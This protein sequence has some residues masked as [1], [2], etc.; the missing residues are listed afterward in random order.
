VLGDCRV[1]FGASQGPRLGEHLGGCPRIER[2][3]MDAARVR[4]SL[5]TCEEKSEKSL[6]FA[7]QWLKSSP[8]LMI[9]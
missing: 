3:A 1:A 7:L 6:I 8:S 4:H 5:P 9:Q 2:L